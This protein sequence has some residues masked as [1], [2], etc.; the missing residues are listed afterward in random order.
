MDEY[1]ECVREV[2]GAAL[3]DHKGAPVTVERFLASRPLRVEIST[4]VGP[5]SLF[6]FAVSLAQVALTHLVQY[7]L[8]R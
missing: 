2:D 7:A 6:G 1:Q 8:T 5:V 3:V 4:R